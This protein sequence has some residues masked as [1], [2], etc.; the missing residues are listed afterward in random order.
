MFG[1]AIFNLQ[2]TLIG[3]FHIQNFDVPEVL[4]AGGVIIVDSRCIHSVEVAT[5][6]AN[7]VILTIVL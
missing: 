3:L 4:V 5:R 7:R 6:E 1:T 2:D